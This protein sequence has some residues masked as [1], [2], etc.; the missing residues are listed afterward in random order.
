MLFM[1]PK[2]EQENLTREQLRI[3]RQIVENE[4]P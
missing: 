4:Y 3:L 1:Y 2:N